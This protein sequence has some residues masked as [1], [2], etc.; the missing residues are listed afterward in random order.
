MVK[1]GLGLYCLASLSHHTYHYYG[2]IYLFNHI[3]ITTELAV[4]DWWTMHPM[5]Q[6]LH[7][8]WS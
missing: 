2:G 6:F 5:G 4:A 8:K 1:R 3:V 7:L